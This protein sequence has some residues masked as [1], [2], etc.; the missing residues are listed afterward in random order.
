[1]TPTAYG[2][3]LDFHRLLQ[4]ELPAEDYA[5][6]EDAKRGFVG[7]L[8]NAEVKR[9]GE[10]EQAGQTIWSHRAYSFLED[11][12][13][14]STV[15]PSLWRQARLNLNHGLFKVTD[16]IYQVRGFDIA[17]I[18][19]IEGDTGLLAIDAQSCVDTAAAALAVYRQFRDPEGKRPL[20]TVMYSHSHGD[21]FGGVRGLVNEADVR[22]G[23]VN[24]I[25]PAGFMHHAVAE[26][27]IAGVAMARRAQFQ[28]GHTLPVG[29]AGQVDSG[30]G[31]NLPKAQPGLIAPTQTINEM[32]E[33]HI[34][35]GV[36]V[37]FQLAPD[38]EAPSEM[39]FFFPGLRAVN[40]AENTN[41]LMHN[42][43]PLRGAQVRDS[44]A[45]SK[46]LNHALH[47]YAGRVDVLMAQHHWPTWGTAQVQKFLT[48]QRDMYRVIHDQT[49]RM[50]NH[51]LKPAE[52]A[53]EL[54]MPKS[55]GALWH[56]RGYYGSLSHNVKAVYQ[57]YLSWYDAHPANLHALPPVPA[58][59]KTIEYMGGIEA[60]LVKAQTDLDKGEYRWVAEVM[61]HA[62]YAHPDHKAARELAANAMEQMGFQAESATWRNAFLLA[63]QEYR[64]GTPKPFTQVLGGTLLP[65]VS[66]A[67]LFDALAVRWNAVRGE[68]VSFSM[69]WHFTDSEEYW[70]IEVSNGAMNSIQVGVAQTVNITVKLTRDV[71]QNILQQKITPADAVQAGQMQLIG[72]A[73]LLRVFF[74]TLDKFVGNFPVVDAAVL[75][76]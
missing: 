53:E 68:G 48:E 24:I 44:L 40:M 4:Q 55:L 47:H 36:E 38:S 17:N 27:V 11:E 63:A 32:F 31:K 34:I 65:A 52:I 60:V 13:P 22:A 70:L 21:H 29:P 28:F 62:V 20:H 58:A 59:K 66:N 39:H 23:K 16:R 45:W 3:T 10:G 61:K 42:L 26:N 72:D 50:M 19:F 57:R 30:L 8:P 71:L 33:T 15:N 54:R 76:E 1:M 14:A 5:D 41:H 67:L 2:A 49:V 7:T 12:T 9:S 74:T 46:Y 75:P 73:S 64:L 37:E 35:D 25:A 6:F 51:G 18:T 43:C 56:A 69:M